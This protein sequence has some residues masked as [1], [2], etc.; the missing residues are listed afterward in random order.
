[1]L[2]TMS[3]PANGFGQG[4]RF[5]QEKEVEMRRTV[6]LVIATLLVIGSVLP[7]C[8]PSTLTIF[9]ITEGNVS[10]MKAGTGNW[11][12]AQ[13]GM[14]LEAGDR[15]KTAD[16]SSAKITFFDGSTVELQADTEI[17]VVSLNIS[18]DTG[19]TTIRLKQAI[20]SIIFRVTK[21]VDPA[22]RYEV[23]TPT[24]VAAVRGSVMQV[25]VI[26]D[27]TTWVT[28]LEGD[29]RAVA[30]G[31]EL[32]IPEGRQCITRP[33]QPPE[34]TITFAV[35]G[36]M[37][38]LQGQMQWDGAQMAADEIN[39]VGGVDVGG[40][41]YKIELL[42]V[43][44]KE[45]TAGEDGSTGTANLQAVIDDVD[46]VV[47]GFRTEVVAVYRD[48]A[49]EAQKIFMNCGAATG[50]LQFSVVTNYD[51]YKYWFKTT[52][53]NEWF[54][55]N[56]SLKITGTIGTVLKQTLEEYGDAVAEGY[57]VPEDGKLRVAIVVEDAAWCAALK[58]GA[59]YYLPVLGYT[60]VGTWL[61]SPTATDISTELSQIAAA[62]PH[63]IYTAFSGPVSDVYFV[64]K[65]DL[66]VPAMTIGIDVPSEHLGHWANTNGKCEGEIMLDTWGVG[67]ANSGATVD[68]FDDF[69]ARFGRYPVYTAATYDAIY[70]LKA[71]MEATDS[72]DADDIIPY[73]ETHS[74]TGV[75]GPYAYYPMPTIEITARQLYALSEVQVAEW[76]DLAS[77]NKTYDQNEWMCGYAFGVQYPHFAHDLVYG[78]GYATGIGSQWQDGMKVGVWPMDF[79]NDYDAALT[80]QYGCWN[81]EY[82][83]TVDVLIPIEGFLAS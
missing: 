37:T 45:A 26:E 4:R 72:L 79:G 20:G 56:T 65:Y 28:N 5:K 23:E 42:K 31:V 52:P 6:F 73:L 80:D 47:G 64:Q 13:V 38:D 70:S 21:I 1:M 14:S 78:P 32:Q 34:L 51:R 18:T 15:V 9:S 43:E 62:K 27:G 33:G 44:T 55:R 74:Y 40:T 36:P 82:P 83:G 2:W 76:Y 46:F 60:V 63:I 3:S 67:L 29:I 7:G 77:H 17:E 10:V 53:Y 11:I 24:G 25:Y 61:V 49:M 69:V 66:A 30:Q 41:N 19:S 58:S 12:E 81:L 54:I 16:N 50:A 22:S 57:R 68:W 71:A 75:G 35:A 39:A 59:Q 48:V 8:A